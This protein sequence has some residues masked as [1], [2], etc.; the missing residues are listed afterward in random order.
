VKALA[1][2]LI[3]SGFSIVDSHDLD[4]YRAQPGNWN[5]QVNQLG[6][7]LF[8]SRIRSVELPG[9]TAYDNRWNAPCQV[10]G[11]SP[12]GWL[13]LGGMVR[14]DRAV[15]YWCGQRIDTVTFASTSPGRE[16]NFNV[17]R[18]A[19]DV[20]IL[21]RPRL[22]EQACGS[23]ALEFVRKHQTLSFD[24]VPASALIELV[25]KLSQLCE[26]RPQLLQQPAVAAG[27]RSSLLRALGECF[28]GL[29]SQDLV[30]TP[31]IREEA[32]HAAVLYAADAPPQAS[33]WG[34]AQALGVSQKA[35]ETAF[36]EA[37]G[38][39]PGKYLGLVRLNHVRHELINAEPSA[40]T[41]TD[42]SLKWGFSNYSRFTRAYR[43][44]FGELPSLT[45]Q[46]SP[47]SK[48]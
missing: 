4:H 26:G 40:M 29:C 31:R 43:E 46:S 37:T 24:A 32:F 38:V 17:E 18:R 2:K 41:I 36:R 35:L 22:L 47:A 3:Q 30:N 39:T 27:F 42:I 45:L 5:V 16:I 15:G 21:I 44:L 11:Q 10:V 7:G 19:H 48:F 12:D 23:D 14:P 20:V 28:A 6:K 34:M 33:V 8:R 1:D 25:L 9:I 13:M